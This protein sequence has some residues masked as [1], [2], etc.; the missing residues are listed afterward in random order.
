MRHLLSALIALL[1]FSLTTI[2]FGQATPQASNP[3]HLNRNAPKKVDRGRTYIEPNMHLHYR[4][5]SLCCPETAWHEH[6]PNE[7]FLKDFKT[8]ESYGRVW[9]N[10]YY[11]AD[12]SFVEGHWHFLEEDKP[13]QASVGESESQNTPVAT[14]T[15]DDLEEQ[16]TSTMVSEGSVW[17]KPYYD[18]DG[19]L[20]QGH[21]RRLPDEK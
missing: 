16:Y 10:G 12:G 1:L 3:G 8:R 15:S 7:P 19:R 2:T 18:K 14:V 5:C 21:W 4:A 6:D 17:V 13:S 20:V 11:C 9:V